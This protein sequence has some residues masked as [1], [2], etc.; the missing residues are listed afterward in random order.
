MKRRLIEMTRFRRR[1]TVVVH[2]TSDHE[3][4]VDLPQNDEEMVRGSEPQEDLNL[5]IRALTGRF[6][7][8]S[9]RIMK[10]EKST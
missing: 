4:K 9:K 3:S 7:Q 6:H 8:I 5:A 1:T 2:G 10:R